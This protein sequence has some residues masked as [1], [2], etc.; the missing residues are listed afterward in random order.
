MKN[1]EKFPFG[2][3]YEVLEKIGR[4]GMG[5][6]YKV[7]DTVRG[8]TL[9]LKELSRQHIDTPAAI[10]GFRNEFRI[11][12]EFRHPN[13]VQ[14]FE[15]GMSQD[16]IPII[17]ME[18]ISGKNLSDLLD[19]SVEQVGDMLIQICQGVAVIHSRLYV[20]RDLKPDNIKLLDDRSVKLLD[21]GLM[22][23]L[24][25]PASAK[26]S[27]TYY[28]MAPE[29]ILG[30]IIDESTDLYSVGVIG[31]EILTGKHPFTGNRKEILQGHLKQ[32]PREPAS[33]RSDIPSSVNSIIM[34]LLEKN[35]DHR[36]RNCSEVLEDLQY[37]TGKRR[38]VE[39]TEQKQGY[40]FSSK[41]VGRAEEIEHFNRYL[42]QLKSG[43]SNALFIAAAAGMGKTRLLNEMKTLTE[44][45]GVRSLYSDSQLAGDHIYGWIKEL[46]RQ[47]APFLD[48]HPIPHPTPCSR[49]P[50]SDLEDIFKT[51]TEQLA[52]VTQ[53]IPLVLFLDDLH[54]MDLKSLEVLNKLIRNRKRFRM[55]IVAGFR[56][57]EVEKTSPLWHT[58]EE[59]LTAYSEL[60]PLTRQ[61]TRDLIGNLLHPSR[62][63]DEFS[64]YCFRNSG[65]N[66]FDLIEFLRYMITERHLT[67]MGSHWSEP[68]N[69]SSLSLPS[70]LEER[71]ALRT[72]RLTPETRAMAD[73]ASVLGDDLDLEIWQAVSEYEENRFFQAIDELIRHQ[74]VVKSEGRYQFG[75]D[76]IRV[77]LYE[78]LSETQKRD[79]HRKTA[80]F[81]ETKL[82]EAYP[83]IVSMIA[84]HFV[85]AQEENKAIEYSVK[86]AKAAEENK[87]EWEAFEHYRHAVCFLEEYNEYPDRASLLL[88]ICE[89]A[90][91][92]NSAAWIDATTCL[93]WLQKAIDA[94]TEKDAKEKVFGLSLSYLVT[95]SISGNYAAARR[96]IPEII[97]KCDVR[98]GTITWAILY[99]SGVCLA[100]WYQGYQADCLEHA[101]RA[102]DIFENRPDALPDDAWTAYS[103]ALFWRDKARAYLGK[104]VDMANVEKIRQ[105]MIEG[106]SDQ[107]IYW[108]T[109]TAVTA[110]AAFTGRWSDL[111][112]WKQ[113]ASQ[114]SREMG[115]IYWFE[116]WISHSYL[117][118][119]IHHGEHSQLENHIERV[120]ASPDPYQVRL[121]WLFR[122]ML[123]LARKDYPQAEQNLSRFLQME[124]DSP[125]NSYLEG[126]VHIGRT[127]LASGSADQ[128][129]RY[130]SRGTRLAAAGPYENPLYQVQFLQLNA[131]L[132]ML[133][134]NYR[135]AEIYLAQSLELA[136]ALDNPIQ[137]GFIR[138]LW[139]RMCIEEKYFEEADVHLT[140]A[141][142]IFLS[143]ENKYQAGQVVTILETL[144][145]HKELQ[146]RE[147]TKD[148]ALLQMQMITEDDDP[149][150][151]RTEAANTKTETEETYLTTKTEIEEDGL[152]RTEID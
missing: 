34:K 55:L 139:G 123:H 19:I 9:A 32:I 67:K 145:Q 120:Q 4:G 152:D 41:I 20:H 143:L 144:M 38:F 61:Q 111:L 107:T 23:Q 51:V 118:G 43:S 79:Y 18:F 37:L 96:K 71:L 8:E 122:G 40:L 27:G 114:L 148:A 103:W 109:L 28:Y 63:S 125:D 82:T 77:A 17:T 131:E 24:G 29:V 92:F 50:A 25:I 66:V 81:L 104:P 16:N 54:R 112:I 6:V 42:T 5:S 127:C 36:Y 98:E 90:A 132:D 89:K 124:E 84:D 151:T 93:R 88:E 59:E 75:H 136:Q 91:Q 72:N 105:L 3:R 33:M 31:Y 149:A 147:E 15:F 95:S 44:L 30:G 73:V 76:K 46:L 85:A 101:Q 69:F 70:K 138:K 12:S 21:Y 115:K 78:R 87:A 26:I 56:N 74:I 130:I 65:G 146:R 142:D 57:D 134:R 121:A 100:D 10:L 47:I 99:G 39:T 150:V 58:V 52:D 64:A 116:C 22:S 106:K 53:G 128:A 35:K 117:Y 135:S 94:Y 11:M 108:H 129:E 86:A 83:D 62:V 13:I 119:A 137:T 45:E 2:K 14:V 1:S 60:N 97:E 141:K 80:N 113:R 126:F 49:D 110:R 68:V 140:L 7:Y 48:K 133:R 102:I